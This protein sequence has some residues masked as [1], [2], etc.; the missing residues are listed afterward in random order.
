MKV[1]VKHFAYWP[2]ATMLY[3]L[4]A[5]QSNNKCLN[6]CQTLRFS[7]HTKSLY[8]CDELCLTCM[9]IQYIL[10]QTLTWKQINCNAYNNLFSSLA[11]WHPCPCIPY[12]TCIQNNFILDQEPGCHVQSLDCYLI[13]HH[14]SSDVD[15]L[16][17]WHAKQ[18]GC[19]LQGQTHTHRFW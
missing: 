13:M 9:N 12:L 5:R 4:V 17:H 2:L 7:S 10:R 8:P 1:N 3:S 18:L 16:N 19:Y 11:K 6:G 14:V 15:V